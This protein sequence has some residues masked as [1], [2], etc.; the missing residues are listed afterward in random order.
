[1]VEEKWETVVPG[2]QETGHMTFFDCWLA[3]IKVEGGW[4]YKN[5]SLIESQQGVAASESM[6][7]VPEQPQQPFKETTLERA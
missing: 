7:F 1:M 6:C 5:T 4:V 2:R 3:K